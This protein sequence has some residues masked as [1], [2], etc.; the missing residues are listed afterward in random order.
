[1]RFE[2]K[3]FSRGM[4]KMIELEVLEQAKFS[5]VFSIA[6]EMTDQIFDN[7]TQKAI[8]ATHQ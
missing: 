4:D 5:I 2:L 8:A 6:K 1:M 3:W 7:P